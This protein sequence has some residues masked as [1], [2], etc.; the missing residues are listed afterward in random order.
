MAMTERTASFVARVPAW[1][2]DE[3]RRRLMLLSWLRPGPLLLPGV[4]M[5]VML[6]CGLFPEWIAPFDPTD[7]TDA[8]LAPPGPEHW[9]GTDHFGRDVLSL[10]IYGA[11]QSLLMGACA[12]FVGGLAGGLLGL[13][14]GYGG[15]G[16]DLVLMRLLDIWMAVP[17]ILLAI[18][19]AAAL[20]PSLT[21]TIIAV[22]LVTVPRY[23]RVMRAQVLAIRSRPF[24]EASRSIG[25]SHTL[26]VLHHILP[27]TVSQMLV[28]A[29]LGIGSSILIGSSLSFIGLGVIDDRPDWGFLL[30]QGR[31]YLTVA[32]WFATFPGLAITA[33][34]ISANLLGDGL[35]SRL[36]PHQRG[37]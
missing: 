32:W 15:R 24:I 31:S 12:V 2:A 5:L 20:G 3:G 17:D 36:D 7:M 27:H 23:A 10:V 29:T 11:R 22:G 26:I 19:I 34:V 18:I 33:L 1:R 21:N 4:I 37:G 9:F 14:S 25:S 8:I 13:V 35:R 6:A 16:V 28:M 30:S